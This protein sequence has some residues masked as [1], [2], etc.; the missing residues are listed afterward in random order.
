MDPGPDMGPDA[1]E[2]DI[3]W[4]SVENIA[5]QNAVEEAQGIPEMVASG[6]SVGS[7]VVSSVGSPDQMQANTTQLQRIISRC[8]CQFFYASF[9]EVENNSLPEVPLPVRAVSFLNI[10]SLTLCIVRNE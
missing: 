5:D 8:K 4:V 7:V 3:L 2:E 10:A 9:G 1:K 6:Q